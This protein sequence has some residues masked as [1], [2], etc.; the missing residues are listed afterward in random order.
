ML[1]HSE[2]Y[3]YIYF[4]FFRS[5][6]Y[7]FADKALIILIRTKAIGCP[8]RNINYTIVYDTCTNTKEWVSGSSESDPRNQVFALHHSTVRL[9]YC[10]LI[11]RLM[12]LYTR[13][14][15]DMAT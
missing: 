12:S 4:F 14:A 1:L 2:I 6:Y 3:I 11:H 5:L 15:R 8:N 9:D 7:R 13:L 10:W